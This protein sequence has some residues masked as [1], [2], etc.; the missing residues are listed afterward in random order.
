VSPLYPS[1]VLLSSFRRSSVCILGHVGLL[2][3]QYIYGVIL[4]FLMKHITLTRS[5][6]LKDNVPEWLMG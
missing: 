1:R 4:V 6:V 2:Q 5:L 3:F